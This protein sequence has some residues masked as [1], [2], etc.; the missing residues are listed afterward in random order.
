MHENGLRG[1][2]RICWLIEEDGRRGVGK[3]WG[4]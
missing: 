2:G 3:G 4:R 1:P